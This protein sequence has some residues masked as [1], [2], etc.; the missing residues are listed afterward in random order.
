MPTLSF[1]IK[2][3]ADKGTIMSPYELLELY[4]YGIDIENKLGTKLVQKIAFSFISESNW[5]A[6][7]QHNGMVTFMLQDTL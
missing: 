4:L 7:E 3:K 6:G 5:L 2:Y 1:E